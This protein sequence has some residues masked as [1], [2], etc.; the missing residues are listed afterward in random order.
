MYRNAECK[1]VHKLDI[2][3]KT[4]LNIS[5]H[6][7]F[8]FSFY[9]VIVMSISSEFCFSFFDSLA[10][11]FFLSFCCLTKLKYILIN[12]LLGFQHIHFMIDYHYHYRLHAAN[13]IFILC[14]FS[15]K[16]LVGTMIRELFRV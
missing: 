6:Y 3:K 16:T 14:L 9:M 2:L 13:L 11:Y 4:F 5:V 8:I 7:L 12:D 15:K 1:T 10:H